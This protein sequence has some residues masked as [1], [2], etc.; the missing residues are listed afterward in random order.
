MLT[1]NGGTLTTGEL[2]NNGTLAFNSG[3][4]A[5]TGA[6]GFEIGSDAL[7]ANVTLGAGANLQVTNTATIASGATLTMNGG[8]FTAG[9]LVNNGTI[10]ANLGTATATGGTNNSSGRIFVSDTLTASGTWT[11]EAGAQLTLENGGL[12]NGAGP[13]ANSGLVTGDGTIAKQFNNFAGGEVRGEFGKTLTFTGATGA[14]AGRLNLL[15]GTLSF[16]QQFTN[17]ATGQINGQGVLYFPSTP[18][19]SNASPTAGLMNAGNINLTGGDSQIYGTVQMQAGSRLIVSGGATASFFDV[20]RHSGTEVRASAASNIVFFGE[21]RGAGNFTGTGTIY[22]EDGYSP[23]NSPALQTFEGNVVFAPSANPEMELGGTTRGTQYDAINVAGKL[24]FDG[25]MDVIL[26]DAFQPQLGN[27]FN[28]FDW[29]TTAGTFHTVNVPALNTGL[30][31]NQSNLYVDGTLSIGLDTVLVSRT[32]DGGGANNDW[33]TNANWSFDVQPLN[34]A[35]ADLI[36]AG[37]VRLAPSVDTAWNVASITFDNTAGAFNITGPQIVTIGA[38]GIANNDT[39]VEAITASVILGADQ[40]FTAASGRLEVDDVN[41]A[42]HALTVAGAGRTELGG[43]NGSG[44]IDKDSTGNLDITGALGAGTVTLNA[45]TGTTNIGADQVFAALNIGASATV[46]L[47]E[48]APAEPLHAIPEPGVTILLASGL[49]GVL[50]R[51][52]RVG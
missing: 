45:N 9:A 27:S 24:T 41:L 20:F 8:S 4:L 32:W 17:S 34:N 37:T 44:I 2:L 36:F 19:P 47:G 18:V 26:I 3:T 21:V 23:G 13:I 25:T 11:N 15:G 33:S 6:G 29:G 49:L 14:N 48:I 52:R 40:S 35:T 1:L 42:G 12:V 7:G 31:W 30:A 22:F 39:E 10:R 28:L 46:V 16:A 43:A 50:G 5:I 51:R 38:G